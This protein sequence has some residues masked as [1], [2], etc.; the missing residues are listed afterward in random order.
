MRLHLLPSLLL[1]A[2]LK[3]LQPQM[4]RSQCLLTRMQIPLKPTGLHPAIR[5]IRAMPTPQP[6]ALQ[7][8][9]C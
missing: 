5:R 2:K 4:T 8:L 1:Q 7:L 9:R 3:R 6:P